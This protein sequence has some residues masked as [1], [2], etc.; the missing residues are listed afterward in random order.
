MKD[1]DMEVGFNPHPSYKIILS[2]LREGGGSSLLRVRRINIDYEI[3]AH[4]SCEFF[5]MSHDF[6]K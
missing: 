4:K 3:I 2:V 5:K 1:V 6:S